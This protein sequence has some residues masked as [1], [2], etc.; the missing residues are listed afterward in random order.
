MVGTPLGRFQNDNSSGRKDFQ[1]KSFCL[2]LMEAVSFFFLREEKKELLC[3][4]VTTFC[5]DAGVCTLAAFD[6]FLQATLWS[7]A[8]VGKVV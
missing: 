2:A 7:F 3:L 4:S 5:G 6:A 1:G 8:S